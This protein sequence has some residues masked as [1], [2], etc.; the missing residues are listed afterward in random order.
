LDAINRPEVPSGMDVWAGDGRFEAV[1]LRFRRALCL[2][3][4]SMRSWRIP[5]RSI[6]DRMPIHE[7]GGAPGGPARPR[8]PRRR[9]SFP[10][11]PSAKWSEPPEAAGKESRNRVRPVLAPWQVHQDL[12]DQAKWWILRAGPGAL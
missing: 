5:A 3:E 4:V 8:W 11:T 1:R 2:S 9:R 10:Q 12:G 6:R 7:V